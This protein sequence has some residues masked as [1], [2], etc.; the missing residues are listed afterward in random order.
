MTW[1]KI[2]TKRFHHRVLPPKDV[3]RNANGEDP[4]QNLLEE[5]DL[6]LHCLS[7][8]TYLSEKLRNTMASA[9][10]VCKFQL[11]I[12]MI[13]ACMLMVLKHQ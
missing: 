5:S 4:N 3:D 9:M 6:G 2:Y 1:L 12:M 8:P 7:R 11:V 13:N 10:A